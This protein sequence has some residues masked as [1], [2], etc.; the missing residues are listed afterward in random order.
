VRFPP[1]DTRDLSAVDIDS[2]EDLERANL[3]VL[4][5]WGGDNPPPSADR[6]AARERPAD[7]VPTRTTVRQVVE[8]RPRS[9]RVSKPTVPHAD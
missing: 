9:G 3:F 6:P 8:E 4:I 2:A 7:R 1:F 5:L